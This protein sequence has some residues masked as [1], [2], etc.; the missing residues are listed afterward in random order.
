LFACK[1]ASSLSSK[2]RCFEAESDNSLRYK[3][4]A[5]R[6]GVDPMTVNNWEA[7]AG[8]TGRLVHR[9]IAFLDTP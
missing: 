9:I 1:S 2:K 6:L 3:D 4:V 7:T 8:P 5:E